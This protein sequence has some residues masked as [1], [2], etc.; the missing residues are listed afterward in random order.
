MYRTSSRRRRTFCDYR[1]T[2]SQQRCV[3]VWALIRWNFSVNR[4]LPSCLTRQLVVRHIVRLSV[5]VVF[6]FLSPIGTFCLHFDLLQR[7]D[8]S[9]NIC[10][11]QSGEAWII[12]NNTSTEIARNRFRNDNKPRGDGSLSGWK[13]EAVARTLSGQRE[14]FVFLLAQSSVNY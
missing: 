8:S 11:S 5:R 6:S 9:T 2:T 4:H 3:N 7:A 13:D 12:S 14:N 10:R 1:P